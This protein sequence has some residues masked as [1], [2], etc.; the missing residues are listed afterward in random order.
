MSL[1]DPHKNKTN[2]RDRGEQGNM[3]RAE[4]PHVVV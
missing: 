3:D 4:Q 1:A 2:P